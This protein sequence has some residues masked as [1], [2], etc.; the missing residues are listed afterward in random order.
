MD[1]DQGLVETRPD[2]VRV[3][4]QSLHKRANALFMEVVEL[5]PSAQ[6]ARLAELATDDLELAQEVRSLLGF[7]CAKPLL[8]ATTRASMM[9]T[10][11]MG[12][13]GEVVDGRYHVHELV[14][15]GGFSYVYRGE[16]L[17]WKRPVALKVI[18]HDGRITERLQE[19]FV[20]E[21]ALLSD[22]SRKTTGI[23]QSYDV[24]L[25]QAPNG[26]SQ[27][28]TALEWLQGRTLAAASRDG[29]WTLPRILQTLAPVARALQIAHESGVAHRD[30]KPSNIFCVEES[31]TRTSKL[32]DFGIAKV[33]SEQGFMQSSGNLK[34]LTAGYAAPEQFIPDLG[35][36]GPWTDVHAL[37]M[38]CVELLLGRHPVPVNDVRGAL[39]AASPTER[40]TPR[41][42]GVAVPLAVE[43]VFEQALRYQPA[44]RYPTAGAFWSQL[45]Q[46]ALAG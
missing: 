5:E 28:F 42:H 34:A 3:T 16:H 6:D 22:L 11:P 45:E 7:A 23:V 17:R 32:L 15:E 41:T 33:A 38:V 37:A 30:I 35:A 27:L 14:A 9:A 19:A 8:K 25:W 29:A 10:D 4:S 1:R 46:A 40:P 21:G 13:V 20:R 24:G 18:K 12:I 2:G 31:G 26:K 36:T 44:D 43:Q 39:K